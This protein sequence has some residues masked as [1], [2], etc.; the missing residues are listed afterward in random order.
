MQQKCH[1]LEEHIKLLKTQIIS[2]HVENG[3]KPIN[4]KSKR[5]EI[6]YPGMIKLYSPIF[7]TQTRLPTIKEIS[8]KKPHKKN[9]MQS[10]K[11]KLITLCN[12]LFSMFTII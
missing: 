3:E 8:P 5:G 12:L 7:Y 10:C 9:I 6:Y 2:G 1:L 11:S 4:Y